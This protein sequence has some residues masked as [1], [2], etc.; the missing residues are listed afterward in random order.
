MLVQADFGGRGPVIP[1]K[2]H[3]NPDL[4]GGAL[5]RC[6]FILS[7]AGVHGVW[8]KTERYRL[9]IYAIGSTGVDELSVVVCKYSDYEMA[10]SDF[11]DPS[12]H[13]A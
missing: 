11:G 4:A 5:A 8:Q 2:R 13:A 1:E 12:G 7:A 10:T 9:P 6:R 3:F